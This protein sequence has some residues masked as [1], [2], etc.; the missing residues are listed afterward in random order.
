[1]A[2]SVKDLQRENEIICDELKKWRENYKNLKEEKEKLYSEML[3]ALKEKDEEIRNLNEINKELENYIDCL[4]KKLSFQNQGKDVAQVAKKSRTLNTFMS[5]AKIAL[6][7][8]KSFG[9]ELKGITAMEQKTG[10]VHSL[11][12]DNTKLGLT[13]Y[14]VRIKKKLSKF[15]SFWINFVLGILFTMSLL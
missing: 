13:V 14:P 15:C 3:I 6:W 9:L 2:I 12:V 4:E 5:R 11:H 7:F 1:M 10:T 8:M